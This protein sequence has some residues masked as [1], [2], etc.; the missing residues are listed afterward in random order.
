MRGIMPVLHFLNVKTGDC[1][2]LKHISGHITVIDVSNAKALTEIQK[3]YDSLL[4]E[5]SKSDRGLLGNF[6]QKAYPVN[7]IKYMADHEYSSVFRFIVTHPDMDHLDGIKAFFE[8]YSPTNLWDTDN[9]ETKDFSS[10]LGTYSEDDWLFY[11]DLRDSRPSTD[12]KRLALL[13]GSRGKYYNEGDEPGSGGDGLHVLAPTADLV[14][15][16]N[17]CG[18]YND[19]SYVILYRTGDFRILFAG[20][21]DDDTWEH[22]LRVHRADVSNVD[23]LI[24][25]HH[26]R[27][28]GRSFDFLQIVKP[29]MTFFGNASSKDLSYGAWS[30]RNLPVIT[31]NQANCMVVNIVNSGMY[32]YVTHE[33]YAKKRNPNTFYDSCMQAYYCE[34]IS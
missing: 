18:D 8:T 34:I 13:S 11:K 5:V 4:S 25:P 22:V 29:K 20:D 1:S 23:L 32:L 2:I 33:T 16:A 10:G 26:G 21:S 19:S 6:N 7:P 31:N 9:V 30:S 12:P 17:D 15:Q 28:S 14:A 27:D 3:S 24:A